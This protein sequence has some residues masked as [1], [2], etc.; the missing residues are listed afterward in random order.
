MSS[1]E[2]VVIDAC[3]IPDGSQ[4]EVIE[5]LRAILDL[6]RLL[7]GFVGG[8]LHLSA[9]GTTVLCYSRMR[10]GMDRQ[11]VENNAEIV[12]AWQDLQAIAT[13]RRKAFEL[14]RVFY[15]PRESRGGDFRSDAI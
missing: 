10:T 8:E 13:P 3:T 11:A 15:P 5:K 9:D 2:S 6:M 1:E 12:A 4:Q 7:D 14:L